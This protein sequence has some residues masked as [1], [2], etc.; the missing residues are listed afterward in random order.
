MK[1]DIV[2]DPFCGSGSI[3]IACEQLGRVAYGIELDEKYVDATV[4][5]Y[6]DFIGKENIRLIRNNVEYSYEEIMEGKK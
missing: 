4:T 1:K 3:I 6:K 2:L 5:R